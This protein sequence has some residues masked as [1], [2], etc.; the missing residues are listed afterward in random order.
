MH[1]DTGWNVLAVSEHDS[2]DAAKDA[3]ERVYS[4][5]NRA[6]QV[7]TFSA[8]EVAAFLEDED[9]GVICSFCGRHPH[10][11]EKL[12]T[13]RDGAAICDRCIRRLREPPDEGGEP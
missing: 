6:W 11:Y 7:A 8:G 12:V 13:G 1:C 3:A 5:V 9:E 4:G 2:I 10:E